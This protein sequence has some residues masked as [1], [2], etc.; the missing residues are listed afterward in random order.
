ME[1]EGGMGGRERD[2]GGRKGWR[3]GRKGRGGGQQEGVRKGRMDG[4]RWKPGRGE[5]HFLFTHSNCM[6]S[7][8]QVMIILELMANG[9]LRNYL[10]S[11][12][13]V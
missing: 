13:P 1:E 3:R 12:R 6:L 11:L 7:S 2:G 8:H 10:K 5:H 9:D 4:R